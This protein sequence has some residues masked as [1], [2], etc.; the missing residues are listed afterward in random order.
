MTAARWLAFVLI[1]CPLIQRNYRQRA[2]GKAPD[3]W[4]WADSLAVSW[5]YLVGMR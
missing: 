2:E 5:G 1:L 4:Y 3:Q